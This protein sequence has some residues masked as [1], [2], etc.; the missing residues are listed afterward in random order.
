M[1]HKQ[2]HKNE[3]EQIYVLNEEKPK[4]KFIIILLNNWFFLII[5]SIIYIIQIYVNMNKNVRFVYFYILF[6]K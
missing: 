5:L 4:I 6:Y 2:N 3:E 1:A